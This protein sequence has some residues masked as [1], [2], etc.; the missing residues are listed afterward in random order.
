MADTDSER[1]GGLYRLRPFDS[2]ANKKGDVVAPF[3]P[4]YVLGYLSREMGYEVGA[5]SERVFDYA[6][7][8]RTYPIHSCD[9]LGED[10]GI[11]GSHHGRATVLV[12]GGCGLAIYV[13]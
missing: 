4:L 12:L 11:K 7:T 5:F 3:L 9:I 6:L 13:L 8:E 10:I 1:E 2:G